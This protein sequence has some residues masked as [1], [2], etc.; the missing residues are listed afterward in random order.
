MNLVDRSSH[1]LVARIGALREAVRHARDRSPFHIDA[2]VVVPDHM[3]CMWTLPQNDADFSARWK[4]IK[5]RFSK[6][7]PT[8][9]HRSAV[10]RRRGE[11]GVWQRRFWEHTIRDDRDYAAHMD[12]IHFNP[13]EHGH[14]QTAAD[15][16]FSSFHRCAAN[17]IYPPSW[18][19][20]DSEPPEAGESR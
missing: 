2:W 3:H 5:T 16:L 13:V 8:I 19:G 7:V 14:V 20:T 17:G 4:A 15:W 9:E 10:N 11:R 12:Y 1:L 18:R 6:S